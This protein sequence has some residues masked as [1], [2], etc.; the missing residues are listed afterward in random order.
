[1]QQDVPSPVVSCS[2]GAARC[3]AIR[4][5]TTLLSF[6]L[7]S[8]GPPLDR[9]TA[10]RASHGK[11]RILILDD[12]FHPKHIVVGAGEEVT[13][14]FLLKGRT[15]CLRKVVIYLDDRHKL[16]QSLCFGAETEVRAHFAR[17]GETGFTCGM[18]M[19][20]GTILVE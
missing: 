19:F 16:S 13:F 3:R 18:A 15:P 6:C 20:G 11:V 17:P 5:V 1:M 14:A 12:G 4:A 2:S 7:G 8:C 9:G 10:V